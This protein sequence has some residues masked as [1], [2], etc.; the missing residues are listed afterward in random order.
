MKAVAEDVSGVSKRPR[1]NA[2]SSKRKNSVEGD[3]STQT[4]EKKKAKVA[5]K[6]T[7]T[8][9]KAKAASKDTGTTTKA[10][11]K[12]KSTPIASL[13]ET[14]APKS[15]S[16]ETSA[17]KAASKKTRSIAKAA[18]NE[19]STTAKEAAR[20]TSALNA[21]LKETRSIAKAATTET[22]TTAKA[23]SKKM[24]AVLEDVDIDDINPAVLINGVDDF[25]KLQQMSELEREIVL[26]DRFQKL[27]EHQDMLLAFKAARSIR[28][29][30]LP[31]L[32]FTPPET[33]T[34]V[35]DEASFLPVTQDM[36]ENDDAAS[37][38]Q[39]IH[40]L[41]SVGSSN[42]SAGSGNSIQFGLDEEDEQF[43]K[44]NEEVFQ[45]MELSAVEA[46]DI[47]T[48]AGGDDRA[49][50]VTVGTVPDA[51][52]DNGACIICK[53]PTSADYNC[54][55]CRRRLHHFCAVDEGFEGHGAKYLCNIGCTGIELPNDLLVENA[56]APDSGNDN[57]AV[58][59]NSNNVGKL[60]SYLSYID[61]VIV[62]CFPNLLY[63][64]FFFR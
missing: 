4:Q 3:D 53:Q 30:E 27:K 12:E 47:T 52:F 22:S 5:S 62:C 56:V 46:G 21:A 44:D 29:I 11:S 57:S 45:A 6:G 15:A 32:T 2:A 26:A 33:E 63:F 58:I 43:V 8:K 14:S 55:R 19:T 36:I 10:A 35:D 20:E 38:M 60:Y 17:P 25:N 28:S 24:S 42:K 1:R 59:S 49:A 31:M 54:Q 50:T 7:N 37:T 9:A 39:R 40:E 48:T 16:K 64:S 34:S 23:A 18:S 41:Q 61:Y 51:A 13:K